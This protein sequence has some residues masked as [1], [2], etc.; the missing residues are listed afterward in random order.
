VAHINRALVSESY[1]V[2]PERFDLQHDT[3]APEDERDDDE[4]KLITH[5]R[6]YFEVLVVDS[7]PLSALCLLASASRAVLSLTRFQAS[8]QSC[9]A[10]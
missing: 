2:R 3:E 7:A 9:D 4:Q 6:L 1:R 10:L 8:A 5:S